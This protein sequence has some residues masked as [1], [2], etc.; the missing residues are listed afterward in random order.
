LRQDNLGHGKTA[1]QNELGYIAEKNGYRHL[2]EDVNRF[3]YA[4]Y[5]KYPY[6]NYVLMGHSMG[7]FIARIAAIKHR[8]DV[9]KL[10]IC[11]TGGPM[12]AAPF[13][14][15]ISEIIKLIYGEKHCSGLMET[16]MFGFY[17]KKFEGISQYDWLTKDREI[18]EKYENDKFCTF[19][20][21]VSAIIDL[22]KLTIISNSP[23]WFKNIDKKLPVLIISGEDDPVGNYGRGVK[24]VFKKLRKEELLNVNMFLYENCRH[25]ILNDSWKEETLKDII[26]F[27][28]QEE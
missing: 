25:E 23:Y 18:V 17:N 2:V 16:L 19:S 26:D 14:Y 13:G 6:K 7:S 22:L 20:F 10:I 8:E 24:K 12:L 27:V 4:V 28:N 11:G 9:D 15:G 21:T 5:Q 3:Y 1:K